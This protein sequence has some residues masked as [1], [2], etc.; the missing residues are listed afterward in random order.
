MG[1]ITPVLL[2]FA[3]L[4]LL[5]SAL[6]FVRGQQQAADARREADALR[7]VHTET[8]ARLD[9]VAAARSRAEDR[10]AHALA[11]LER[12]RSQLAE[13]RRES[14]ALQQ[15]QDALADENRR[16][17]SRLSRLDD[18]SSLL[19]A[20][21]LALLQTPAEASPT[22]VESPVLATFVSAPETVVTILGQGGTRL[23]LALPGEPPAPG[24]TLHLRF[25]SGDASVRVLLVRPRFFIAELVVPDAVLRVAPGA[26]AT[27]ISSL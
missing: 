22:V 9:E 1:R 10:L 4:C 20:E 18:E 11:D 23:A 13:T 24:A 26:T 15:A 2:L 12:A 16:L 17:Q 7:Q 6:L 14:E 25:A 5:G 27:L 8:R 3:G 21:I 19:R